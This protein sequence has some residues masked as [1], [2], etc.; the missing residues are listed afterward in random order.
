[1]KTQCWT[2]CIS[3]ALVDVANAEKSGRLVRDVVLL[4]SSTECPGSPAR[5]HRN[6]TQRGLRAVL[7]GDMLR[8]VFVE[9]LGSGC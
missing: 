5:G 3:L 1:M 7:N 9:T 4:H 8:K 2:S 6:S